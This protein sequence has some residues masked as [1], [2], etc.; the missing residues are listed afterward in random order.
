M[1]ELDSYLFFLF[2]NSRGRMPRT[3]ARSD[4]ATRYSFP[5]TCVEHPFLAPFFHSRYLLE[6]N[7]RKSER[8]TGISTPERNATQRLKSNCCPCL[9]RRSSCGTHSPSFFPPNDRTWKEHNRRAFVSSSSFLFFF[10]V[11]MILVV[12]HEIRGRPRSR[13]ETQKKINNEAQKKKNTLKERK[14]EETPPLDGK[15]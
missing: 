14:K 15:G 5:V 11:V 10:F 9:R 2:K 6:R 1:N 4:Y 13:S 3:S 8:A 12:R 7:E